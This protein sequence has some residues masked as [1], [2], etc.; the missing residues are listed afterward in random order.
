MRVA[1][2]SKRRTGPFTRTLLWLGR[3]ETAKLT[4]KE[5]TT[6]MI[7]PAQAYSHAPGL[8]L[9]YGLFELAVAK[10]HRVPERL[11]VLAELKA[12]A[13][14]RCEWCID[15][16][17]PIAY[18]AGIVEAQILALAHHRASDRFSELEKL[19]LDFAVGISSTPVSVSDEL[20]AKL[21]E[22]LD[23]AQLV[24]LA[25]VIALENMRGRFN[26]ALG[27]GPAGFSEGLVCALPETAP[28]AGAATAGATR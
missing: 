11:K 24:E 8:L 27:I 10:A 14:T 4:G 26:L 18:R 6:E 5:T 21:R 16:G 25:N 28:D 22:H 1:G 9:G 7:E 23:D 17:S 20:F 19:V 12:A 3:R 2:T 13:L 15:V